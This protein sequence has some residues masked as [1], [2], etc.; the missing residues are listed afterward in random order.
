M[1]L[2]NFGS[3]KKKYLDDINTKLKWLFPF[4]YRAIE[5]D[6]EDIKPTICTRVFCSKIYT[7]LKLFYTH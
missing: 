1:S 2:L 6:K 4:L 7:I 3:A 5:Q